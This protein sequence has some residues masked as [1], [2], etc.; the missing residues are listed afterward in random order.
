MHVHLQVQAPVS[1]F[2]YS[3]SHKFLTAVLSLYILHD[4]PQIKFTFIGNISKTYL[5]DISK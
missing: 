4:L 5:V 2:P 1:S 3:H